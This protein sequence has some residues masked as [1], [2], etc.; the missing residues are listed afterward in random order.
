MYISSIRIWNRV[1]FRW[2]L[3]H[4]MESIYSVL[5]IEIWFDDQYITLVLDSWFEIVR[6]LLKDDMLTTSWIR[7]LI[8]DFRNCHREFKIC[9]SYRFVEFRGIWNWN[10]DLKT[11]YVGHL[12]ECLIFVFGI[13]LFLGLNKIIW[14]GQ[15]PY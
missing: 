11:W 2:Y 15:V 9:T 5:G 12:M 7:F 10:R 14:K 4:F 8:I 3:D 13:E 6:E 1:L